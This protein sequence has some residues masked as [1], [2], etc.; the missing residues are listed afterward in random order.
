MNHLAYCVARDTECIG[1]GR[2]VSTFESITT[3]QVSSVYIA[4]E[5]AGAAGIS[6]PR[7]YRVRNYIPRRHSAEH[8]SHRAELKRTGLFRFPSGSHP[9]GWLR[10]SSVHSGSLLAPVSIATFIA[11]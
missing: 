5:A 10:E 1:S 3:S 9:T 6:S 8:N 2:H 7:G 4:T 11:T